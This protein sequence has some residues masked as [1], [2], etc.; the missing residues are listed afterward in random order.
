MYSKC[1][2]LYYLLS[3]MINNSENL[4]EISESSKASEIIEYTQKD[5]QVVLF[6]FSNSFEDDYIPYSQMILRTWVEKLW[7]S[8]L[9]GPFDKRVLKYTESKESL[10][11]N[12]E[13][14]ESFQLV[15]ISVDYETIPELIELSKTI[16]SWKP[17]WT[18]IVAWGQWTASEDVRKYLFDS[19]Y[20]DAINIWHAQPF[21]DFL[22]NAKNTEILSRDSLFENAKLL[23]ATVSEISVPEWGFPRLSSLPLMLKYIEDK[24]TKQ[25]KT[26]LRIPHY[27]NCPNHCDYCAQQKTKNS[28]EIFD[29]IIKAI[30]EPKSKNVQIDY[31]RFEW[32]T[33]EGRIVETSKAI[34]NAIKNNQWF[35][36]SSQITMDSKQFQKENYDNTMSSLEE[37]NATSI[38]IWINS[39]DWNTASEVW[40]KNNG[41]VRTEE[42]LQDEILW[43]LHFVENS[44]IDDFKIDMLLS[45]FDTE[46]S[47]ERI[48]DFNK[49]LLQ[50]QKKTGKKIRLFLSPLIPYPWTPLFQRHK[51]KINFT[52]YSQLK[53]SSLYDPTLR[54][55]DESLFGSQFLR[56]FSAPFFTSTSN[57]LTKK[58]PFKEEYLQFLALSMTYQYFQWKTTLAE[59]DILYPEYR[60][61]KWVIAIFNAIKTQSND[62]MLHSRR[63]KYFKNHPAKI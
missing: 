5:L 15:W 46:S 13:S 44:K 7:L 12:F 34:L 18:F 54:K 52:D 43:V 19:W 53:S 8:L 38:H 1:E 42:E 45:P 51:D 6:H 58:E 4:S 48:I 26:Q 32:P 17:E 10:A 57:Y 55:D 29:S 36:P 25:K 2:Y 11:K 24:K 39:V 30:E 3:V 49:K 60:K 16:K 37:V 28:K 20:I 9:S 59:M 56:K 33:F 41:R 14:D 63:R 22:S 21:F 27:Q 35:M 50:I 31:V 40:R 62:L 61:D 47:I 23:L